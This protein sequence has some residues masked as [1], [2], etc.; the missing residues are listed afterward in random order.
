MKKLFSGIGAILTLLVLVFIIVMM[1]VIGMG[2]TSYVGFGFVVAAIVIGLFLWD[3]HGADD[4]D[5]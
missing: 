4:K 5:T 3:R 1:T 2:S